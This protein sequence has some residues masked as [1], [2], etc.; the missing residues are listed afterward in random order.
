MITCPVA[1]HVLPSHPVS[2]PLDWQNE[3]FT[4]NMASGEEVESPVAGASDLAAMFQ[5]DTDGT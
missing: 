2:G 3:A 4:S 1:D 5:I